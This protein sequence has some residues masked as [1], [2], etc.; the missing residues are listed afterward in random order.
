[1]RT[2][3]EWIGKTDDSKVP[4][5]VRQ[6]V[7][8]NAGGICHCCN[9]P[10]KVPF[11]T[12]EADHKIALIN[13]GEN[14]ESNLAPAHSHCHLKKTSVDVAEKS[15]VAAIRQKFTGAKKPKSKLARKEKQTK[16][17]SKALPPRKRDIFGRPV[18]EGARA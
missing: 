17:L 15:K 14:R 8:D 10:I 11:E 5:R 16:P 12:W 13:G 3:K 18:S 4:D 2:V 7:F 9:L 1:M 6:R